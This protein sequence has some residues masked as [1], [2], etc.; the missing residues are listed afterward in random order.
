MCANERNRS[1]VTLLLLSSILL[2]PCDYA[3]TRT[4]QVLQTFTKRYIFRGVKTQSRVRS[5]RMNSCFRTLDFFIF[6][7]VACKPNL[8]K[9]RQRYRINSGSLLPAETGTFAIIQRF[10]LGL[11]YF[12]RLRFGPRIIFEFIFQN[13]SFSL[14]VFEITTYEIKTFQRN[15]GFSSSSLA[16]YV[17]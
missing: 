7:I 8:V 3:A 4:K 16:I 9:S 10:W 5:T 6:T 12:L 17:Y 1:T 2:T 11:C 14:S 15:S 13:V